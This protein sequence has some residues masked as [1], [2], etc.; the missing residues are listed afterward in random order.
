MK[1]KGK[2]KLDLT[3]ETQ[4][5]PTFPLGAV[6]HL[7]LLA[8]LQVRTR[9]GVG[10]RGGA[11]QLLGAAAVQAVF[12][13][14]GG[15][16]TFRGGLQ[17]PTVA[18]ERAPGGAGSLTDGAAW[19]HGEVL[20]ETNKTDNMKLRAEARS[21]RG[22]KRLMIVNRSSMRLNLASLFSPAFFFF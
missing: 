3:W 2:S 12:A 20:T 19:D 21:S 4:L 22:T 6:V 1:P 17:T 5:A 18:A 16:D 7:R 14:V 10:C 11:Q 8:V 15:A 13:A 9:Q